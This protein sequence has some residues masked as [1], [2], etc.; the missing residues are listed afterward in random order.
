MPSISRVAASLL[1]LSVLICFAYS[2]SIDLQ[3]VK[4]HQRQFTQS[5]ARLQ[6]VMQKANAAAS[7]DYPMDGNVYPVGI[8]WTKVAIGTPPQYFQVAVDSGYV[9]LSLSLSL[10]YVLVLKS[11]SYS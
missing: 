10:S 1:L 8:Y 5:V 11:L 2:K 4:H 7:Y 6:R 3:L 9:S